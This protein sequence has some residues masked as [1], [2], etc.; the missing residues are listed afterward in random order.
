[1]PVAPPVTIAERSAS[2][3]DP[4]DPSPL[5]DRCQRLVQGG[6]PRQREK[7]MPG[8]SDTADK[9]AIRVIVE[10]WAVYRDGLMW[11]R[12]R[13][14]WH[15]DG[16]MWATWFEGTAAEFIEASKRGYANGVRVIHQ[17]GGSSIDLKGK[18]A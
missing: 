13:T 1:M 7:T 14:V 10:N 5:L 11:D 2:L 8:R 3:M 16:R 17:L 4:M 18:R 9:L 12:F 15:D 6:A